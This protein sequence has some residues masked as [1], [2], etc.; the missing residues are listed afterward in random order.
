[1]T[2]VVATTKVALVMPAGTI[3]LGGTVTTELLLVDKLM[4][5]PPEGAALPKVMVPVEVLP[6]VRDVGLKLNAE[7]VG[8]FTVRFAFRVVAP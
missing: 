5:A 4:T 2:G 1:M 8:A 7:K 6:P 3:T